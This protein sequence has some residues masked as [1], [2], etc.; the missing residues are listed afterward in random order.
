MD[1]RQYMGSK[2]GSHVALVEGRSN[3]F[4]LSECSCLCSWFFDYKKAECFSLYIIMQLD[5]H[6]WDQVDLIDRLDQ[7]ASVLQT[8]TSH[9][10]LDEVGRN[11][12][13]YIRVNNLHFLYY[14]LQLLCDKTRTHCTL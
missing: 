5:L 9:V 2:V 7:V 3:F 6:T 12:G 10:A 1:Y 4:F 11:K 8:W 14:H 13:N